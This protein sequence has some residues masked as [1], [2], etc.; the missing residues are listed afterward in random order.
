MIAPWQTRT[1]QPASAPADDT[2]AD[3]AGAGRGTGGAIVDFGQPNTGP[4]KDVHRFMTRPPDTTGSE[5]DSESA[6]VPARSPEH[7][8]RT[9]GVVISGSGRLSL[10]DD[11]LADNPLIRLLMDSTNEDFDVEALVP[12][13]AGQPLLCL[14]VYFCNCYFLVEVLELELPLVQK[15]ML[16]VEASYRP[17]PY[18]SSLHAADVVLS[19]VR[20]LKCS[21]FPVVLTSLEL[22]AV[23]T[24][25]AGEKFKL[26]LS[27]LSARNVSCFVDI[28][29]HDVDH[30]G[31]NNSFMSSTNHE[32]ALQHNDQ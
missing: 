28:V 23:I 22:L 26:V 8:R 17:L 7:G 6:V 27:A 4:S 30:P 16:E 3:E 9:S 15:F 13:T 32:T 18:H 20:L 29:V 19:A 21:R 11:D 10:N 24:A 14:G 25:C 12:F 2:G 31:V 1:V 5:S